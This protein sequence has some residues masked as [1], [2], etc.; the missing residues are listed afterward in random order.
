MLC[1]STAVYAVVTGTGYHKITTH[2]EGV[3]HV[4]TEK[5]LGLYFNH[6][7]VILVACLHRLAILN[8]NFIYISVTI[9]QRNAIK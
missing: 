1:I 8:H 2:K 3:H 7:L 5:T 9:I 4:H 6:I